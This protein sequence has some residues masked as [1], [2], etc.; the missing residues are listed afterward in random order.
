MYWSVFVIVGAFKDIQYFLFV[1]CCNAIYINNVEID[2]IS[3]GANE[4]L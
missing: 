4:R 1:L 3:L 2:E